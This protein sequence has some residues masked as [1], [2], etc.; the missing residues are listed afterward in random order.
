MAVEVVLQ[1]AVLRPPSGSNVAW[2][3]PGAASGRLPS[4]AVEVDPSHVDV[5]LSLCLRRVL[6]SS[7][8]RVVLA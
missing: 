5:V 1:L 8:G 2:C 3:A 4:M 6:L 7:T